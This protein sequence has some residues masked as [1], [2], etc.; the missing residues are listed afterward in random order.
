MEIKK[1]KKSGLSTRNAE[2]KIKF[3]FSKNIL[4]LFIGY[5]IR[6]DVSKM[7]LNNL[8]K[9]LDITDER[10]YEMD[11]ELYSRLALAK[12]ILQARC[13]DGLDKKD[14]IISYCS[15]NND[16][17]TNRLLA[18][19][20]ELASLSENEI[21]FIHNAVK[22]RLQYSFLVYFKEIIIN[23]F[24]RLDTGDYKSYKEIV[25]SVKE[26][27]GNLMNYI[28]KADISDSNMVFSLRPEVFDQ[29][30]MET[31]EAES[32]PSAALLTGVEM[33][34]KMLSP[35]YLQGRLYIWLG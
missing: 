14:V 3:S 7:H 33:L 24:M 35:G 16:S 10:A 26:K 22:D 19:I 27:C 30:V 29:L 12:N 20:D 17:T 11:V 34:N 9:L 5:A 1:H 32:N 21:N 8:Y 2:D 15:K 4:N 23:E 6:P 28:R 25:E 18:E 31:V 13:K